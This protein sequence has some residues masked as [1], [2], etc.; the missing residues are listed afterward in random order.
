MGP[1]RSVL[2]QL[3]SVESGAL[4]F[5]TS[6]AGNLIYV[7]GGGSRGRPAWITRAG[8]ATVLQDDW[9]QDF[10]ALVLSPDGTRLAASSTAGT[11]QDLWVRSSEVGDIPPQRRSFGETGVTRPVFAP[12]GDTVLYVGTSE[13]APGMQILA[14]RWDG[15]GGMSVVVDAPQMGSER[16][17]QE[18]DISRDGRWLVYRVGGGNVT[19]DIYLFEVGRDT[20]GR[21]LIA[22]QANEHSPR[23]SPDGRF[24]AYGSNESGSDEIYAR[25]FPDLSGGKWL[26]SPAGGTEPVWSSDG[27]ELFYK[28]REGTLIATRWSASGGVLSL[29]KLF[30]AR[31]FFADPVHAAYAVHPDGRFLMVELAENPETGVVWIE[32]F[33][34]LLD[35]SVGRE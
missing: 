11:R 17:V 20:V 9:L 33:S 15:T 3:R 23:I 16:G 26:I 12:G 31:P 13:G 1:P 4:D 35:Q 14:R 34:T 8:E 24:I 29:E 2:D 10:S 32:G 22:E 27:S 19:R 5:S 30:D 7:S 25:T 28:D 18:V 21:P 6:A